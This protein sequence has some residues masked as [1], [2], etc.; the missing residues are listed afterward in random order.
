MNTHSS[1]LPN[2]LETVYEQERDTI[3]E[4]SESIE[5]KSLM[6]YKASDGSSSYDPI[7]QTP[8]SLSRRMSIETMNGSENYDNEVWYTPREYMPTN[9]IENIEVND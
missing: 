3:P 1:R 7:A 5:Q 8:I 6:R 2:T 4:I 9:L